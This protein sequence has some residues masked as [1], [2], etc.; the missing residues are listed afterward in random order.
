M[1]KVNSKGQIYNF[2]WPAIPENADPDGCPAISINP[3]DKYVRGIRLS[4]KE[5]EA[6][7][8]V[9]GISENQLISC[10]HWR[11]ETLNRY[12]FDCLCGKC[13][14]HGEPN[15]SSYNWP[16][17]RLTCKGNPFFETDSLSILADSYFVDPRKLTAKEFD[18]TKTKISYV[19]FIGDGM[20][21]KIGKADDAIKRLAGLQTGN[22]RE[23]TLF[24]VIVSEEQWRAIQ[25]EKA[26]HETFKAFRVGETEWFNILPMLDTAQ[27]A[28]FLFKCLGI[29]RYVLNTDSLMRFRKDLSESLPAKRE[30]PVEK[31]EQ[32]E[33][34]RYLT[35]AEAALITGL[36]KNFLSKAI[37]AQKLFYYK[38]TRVIARNVLDEYLTELT[39]ESTERRRQAINAVESLLTSSDKQEVI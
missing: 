9:C 5:I 30:I 21:V 7:K 3:H 13:A 33:Q 4:S 27:K 12:D 16:N 32:I 29:D 35:L 6:F 18:G 23:L 15:S 22:P 25:I 11:N 31:I 24:Y 26:L 14:N 17:T 20:Y 36:S 34:K 37:K 10:H 39:R 28:R 2:E 19:Y 1:L 38:D 8:D